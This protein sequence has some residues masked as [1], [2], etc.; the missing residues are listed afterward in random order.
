MKWLCGYLHSS[1]RPSPGTPIRPHKPSANSIPGVLIRLHNPIHCSGCPVEGEIRLVLWQLRE[2]GIEHVR[3]E[4]RGRATTRVTRG[5]PAQTE[6]IPLVHIDIPLWTY[7][8][9]EDEPDLGHVLVSKSFSFQLPPELPPTLYNSG[10]TTE[11]EVKYAITV[12]G[13]RPEDP[14]H[15]RRMHIPIVVVPPSDN[16]QLLDVKARLSGT[17]TMADIV[18]WRTERAE[19]R[20]RRA[21]WGRHA[22]AQVQL[23]IPDLSALPLYTKILFVIDIL[24][25]SPLLTRAKADTSSQHR[26]VFPAVPAEF[27]MLEFKLRRRISLRAGTLKD[28]VSSDVATFTKAALVI[29][30]VQA[31][32]PPSRWQPLPDADEKSAGALGRWVQRSSFRSTF[33][34]ACAP[35]FTTETIDC[36]YSLELTVPFAGAGNDVRISWPIR[37]SSGLDAPAARDKLDSPAPLLALENFLDLPLLYWD[38]NVDEWDG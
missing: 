17:V 14:Q 19:K 31:E 38:A 29:S 7:E 28:D 34:L 37:V 20:I 5:H 1:R 35:S 21:P 11:A 16:R 10:R 12:V 6:T 33:Q 26:P 32:T 36:Q 27:T 9:L 13:V 3:L 22:T 25:T 24:T 23:T 2:D 15:H 30:A 4:L 8:G 18:P